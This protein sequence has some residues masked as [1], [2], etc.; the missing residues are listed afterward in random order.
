MQGAISKTFARI[1]ASLHARRFEFQNVME[2]QVTTFLAR[3]DAIFTLNQDTLLEHHYFRH[4][5]LRNPEKWHSPQLP[6]MRR[7][8]NRETLDPASWAHDTFV[9][10]DPPQLQINER[11]QPIFKLHGSSN[12][13]DAE[14]GHLLIF[15]GNKARAIAR[16]PVLQW[17]LEQ[18]RE[19]LAKPQTQLMVIGYGFRDD[20]IN[21]VI[22]EAVTR[23]LR[24]FVVDTNGRDVVRRA[25]PSWGGDIYKP[26][27]LDDAF[28]TGLIRANSRGLAE[29]FGDDDYSFADLMDF[30][31]A[32]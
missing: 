9:P 16:H 23:G 18:F 17:S 28:D 25:N 32:A 5:D 15:G 30:F 6:G 11:S 2:R 10:F 1:N 27:E 7:I 13:R 14:G 12:W 26:N 19:Y 31:A 24:F 4:L 3:F 22:I 20:H 8:R 21:R 29:T